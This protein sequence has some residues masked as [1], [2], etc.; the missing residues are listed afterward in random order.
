[1]ILDLSY[2]NP[3]STWIRFKQLPLSS[4]DISAVISLFEPV[5]VTSLGTID[6]VLLDSRTIVIRTPALR[7]ISCIHLLGKDNMYVD[8]P[9]NYILRTSL[10]SDTAAINNFGLSD[11]SN[12]HFMIMSHISHHIYICHNRIYSNI[13]IGHL[14]AGGSTSL[15]LNNGENHLC[16]TRDLICVP[17]VLILIMPRIRPVQNNSGVSQ[18][19]R[20]YS[21]L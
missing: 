8:L 11:W 1:L 21:V 7:C 18:I 12:K 5:I 13:Y 15:W 20:I 10:F 16:N 3:T 17:D 9:V 19:F 4:C 2:C 14:A 6:R